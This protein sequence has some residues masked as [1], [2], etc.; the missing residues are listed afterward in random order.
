VI[1]LAVLEI[2]ENR[3]I[4]IPE[5]EFNYDLGKRRVQCAQCSDRWVKGCLNKSCNAFR[6]I[7]GYYYCIKK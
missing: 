7:N 6:N 4:S 3:S 5:V 1:N 2:N